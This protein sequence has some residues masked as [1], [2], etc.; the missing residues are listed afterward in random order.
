M[1]LRLCGRSG[2]AA[3]AY[4]VIHVLCTVHYIV[5][6]LAAWEEFICN[7]NK[8]INTGGWFLSS[9]FLSLSILST[10]TN[11][12]IG[13]HIFFDRCLIVDNFKLRSLLR[14]ALKI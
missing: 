4:H 14:Y 9:K 8:K 3:L 10:S 1:T 13:S 2:N 11:R 6:N 7:S 5:D 12:S